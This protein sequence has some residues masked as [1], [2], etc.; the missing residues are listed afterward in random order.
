MRW[1][2]FPRYWNFLWGIHRLPIDPSHEEPVRH[3]FVASLNKLLN[4]Q[5]LQI[6]SDAMNRK[7][8]HCDTVMLTHR[9]WKRIAIKSSKKGKS[10]PFCISLPPMRATWR[11]N[12]RDSSLHIIL[13][14]MFEGSL[15]LYW[16]SVLVLQNLQ[17]LGGHT[18]LSSTNNSCNC[19]NMKYYLCKVLMWKS[20][21]FPDPLFIWQWWFIW[22]FCWC[23]FQYWLIVAFFGHN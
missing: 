23:W 18:I 16:Q 9:I 10:M 11:H 7:W 6:I 13:V 19:E 2:H 4:K 8:H 17:I 12:Q 20:L 21:L 14:N 3:W 15:H 5:E 1:A 22:N